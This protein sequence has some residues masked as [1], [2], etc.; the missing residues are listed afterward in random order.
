MC[1][2]NKQKKKAEEAEKKYQAKVKDKA[3]FLVSDHIN[4]F[5][6]PQTP[7]I[8]NEDVTIIQNINWGLI[9]HWA[10][11]QEIRKYTV[12]AKMETLYDKPAFK[13]VVQNR[14]IILSD[15]FYEWQWR[16]SKGKNK[17]KHLIEIAEGELFAFGGLYS[18]WYN[19][20]TGAIEKT[21]T[22][23]TTEAKGMM[24][25]VHNSKMRMPVILTEEN[26]QAWLGGE[27]F[28]AFTEISPRLSATPIIEN[29]MLSLF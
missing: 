12:N 13:D 18:E 16:D 1:F 15:G 22:I 7:V 29:G 9:P 4:A 10:K 11:D 23:V 14:C 2:H 24:R 21:Y 6:F 28:K 5:T 19:T 3:N 26:D 20:S 25:E 8:T 27:D 17:L